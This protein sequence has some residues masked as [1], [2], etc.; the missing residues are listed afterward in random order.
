VLAVQER[1]TSWVPVP[2]SAT[3]CG[4]PLALSAMLREAVHVSES[5]GVIKTAILQLLPAASEE[6][7]VLASVKSEAFVPLSET[8]VMLKAAL[9]VLLSVTV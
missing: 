7:H 6:P 4:L 3:D 2:D 5:E 1:T 8:P 9:P